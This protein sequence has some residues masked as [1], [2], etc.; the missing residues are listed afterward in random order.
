MSKKIKSVRCYQSVTFEKQQHNSFST[1]AIPNR[2][3]V[4]ITLEKLGSSTDVIEIT[5]GKDMVHIP[6]TNISGIYYFNEADKA[7]KAAKTKEEENAKEVNEMLTK[8]GRVK[9]PR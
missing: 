1:I 9:K 3:M 8:G 4:E 5:S 6:L 7:K 2:P